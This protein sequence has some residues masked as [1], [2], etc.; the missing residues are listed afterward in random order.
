MEDY[1]STHIYL[2][3]FS[4]SSAEYK[5]QLF[6]FFHLCCILT[7]LLSPPITIFSVTLI[8]RYTLIS[9][10]GYFRLIQIATRHL[11]NEGSANLVFIQTGQH[12]PRASNFLQCCLGIS[13]KIKSLCTKESCRK[14]SAPPTINCIGSE[15]KMFESNLSKRSS[16]NG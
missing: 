14:A 5:K 13:F 1:S 8:I 15:Y 3:S 6:H 4:F 9:I 11:C 10:S 16:L 12:F 7:P 2:F